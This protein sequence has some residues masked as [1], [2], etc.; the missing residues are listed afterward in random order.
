MR[1]DAYVVLESVAKYWAK[2]IRLYTCCVR[3]ACTYVTV[4]MRCLFLG[5][6]G[7]KGKRAARKALGGRDAAI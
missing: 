3:T 7:G 5:E 4:R 1:D 2:V 6:K